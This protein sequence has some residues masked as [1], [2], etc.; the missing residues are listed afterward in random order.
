MLV[1]L[2]LLLL[3]PYNSNAHTMPCSPTMLGC[4][5]TVGEHGKTLTTTLQ[6]LVNR[7]STRTTAAAPCTMPTPHKPHQLHSH[8]IINQQ[9]E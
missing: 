6:H 3:L 8:T 4:A 1:L 2:L 7:R 9:Q 5:S